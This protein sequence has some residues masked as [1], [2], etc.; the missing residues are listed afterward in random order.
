MPHETLDGLA[1]DARRL[2]AAGA[3]AARD[4]RALKRRAKE[5]RALAE[6]VPALAPVAEAVGRLAKGDDAPRALAELLV[7]LVPVRASLAKAGVEG[8]VEPAPPSGPWTTDLRLDEPVFTN[9]VPQLIDSHSRPLNSLI[10]ADHEEFGS[11]LRLVG[12]MLKGLEH[13]NRDGSERVAGILPRF[14]KAILNELRADFDPRGGRTDVLRLRVLCAIDRDAGLAACR[15]ALAEGSKEVRVEALERLAKLDPEEAAEIALRLLKE[16]RTPDALR[17]AAYAVLGASKCDA[18]LEAL[19]AA[20]QPGIV[21]RDDVVRAL[22][23]SAHPEA[24]A[25]MLER[26]RALVAE[27][28]G[29]ST[30]DPARRLMGVLIERRDPEALREFLRWLEHPNKELRDWA[31]E[32]FEVFKD[33]GIP[34]AAEV[35]PLLRHKD[36]RVRVGT[37]EILAR[38]GNAD[39]VPSLVALLRDKRV[40][41]RELAVRAL[42]QV[43]PPP[44]EAVAAVAADLCDDTSP[45]VRT[46][47][48]VAIGGW[49]EAR[50]TLP[51]LIAALKDRD[52]RVRSSAVTALGTIGPAAA[53]ALP[54]LLAARHDAYASIRHQA[55]SA[56]CQLAPA[57]LPLLTEMLRDPARAG[58]V[59][60]ALRYRADVHS[61]L[62]REIVTVA[63]TEG[64]PRRAGAV[65]RLGDLG[66][67]A[68]PGVSA[69]IAALADERDEVREAAA[70]AAWKLARYVPLPVAPLVSAL[71]D[72]SR[73]VR[74]E[75]VGALKNLGPAA[76]EAVP[77]LRQALND[78]DFLVR[79]HAREALRALGVDW[80][81]PR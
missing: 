11:E 34:V 19:L 36:A 3:T 61:D 71:K 9:T 27:G 66:A 33:R 20:V 41:V 44:E 51:A 46:S 53:E 22:E 15:P 57:S 35:A 48:A 77:A 68:A 45:A 64:H 58:E 69:V 16:R 28:D 43:A 52:D 59:L 70:E 60:S 55:M 6:Q 40:M 17:E 56:L 65:A 25:R 79:D 29:G 21:G 38:A 10:L 8:K 72:R 74:M 54:A 2:L 80:H 12:P 24:A 31:R 37:L 81:S 62:I 39:A 50:G 1:E 4:D 49:K 78:D 42:G 47:A 26:V 63:E 73:R 67:A 14:G 5:V 7:L 13:P 30:G 75:T 76:V 23:K 32:W 18:A